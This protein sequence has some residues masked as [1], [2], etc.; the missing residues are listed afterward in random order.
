M[1]GTRFFKFVLLCLTIAA[2]IY[3]MYVLFLKIKAAAA[4][5]SFMPIIITSAVV[6]CS[7]ICTAVVLGL[8]ICFAIY[9]MKPSK[10]IEGEQKVT[11]DDFILS[12]EI[13]EELRMICNDISQEKKVMFEKVGFKPPQ[14]YLLYGPPGNGKTLLARAVAG[15]ANISFES[16]SASEL[17]GK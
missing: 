10:V 11:L 3:L 12:D 5:I 4:T 6:T 16:I 13:K 17:V 2:F 15:E 14:G 1:S 7:V 9:L 8:A